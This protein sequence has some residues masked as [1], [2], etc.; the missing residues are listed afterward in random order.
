M[1]EPTLFDVDPA[2]VPEPEPTLSADRRRTLRQKAAVANGRHP[3]TGGR[4]FPD[5]GTCGSCAHRILLR[6]HDRTWPK[7]GVGPSSHSAATDVR[8]WWPACGRYEPGDRISDDAAR[9]TPDH[10]DEVAR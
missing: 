6:H 9:W 10:A 8:A 5:M 2:P 3:L 4:A 1:T 7:C